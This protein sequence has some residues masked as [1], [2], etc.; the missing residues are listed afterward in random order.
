M[1][2]E[3]VSDHGRLLGYARSKVLVF[4]M[5]SERVECIFSLK[6]NAESSRH[7]FARESLD[8]FVGE[9][10]MNGVNENGIVVTIKENC[11]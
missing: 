1:M 10:Q 9:D 11:V 8:G 3:G 2:G 4:W 6:G 5:V 7:K